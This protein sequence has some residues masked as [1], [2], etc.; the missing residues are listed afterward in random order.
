[1]WLIMPLLDDYSELPRK[2]LK[3]HCSNCG[4]EIVTIYL[5]PGD[6]LV[7]K[8]CNIETVVPVNSEESDGETT[9]D[10]LRQQTVKKE[11]HPTEYNHDSMEPS[12]WGISS[13]VKLICVYIIGFVALAIIG[14]C[15]FTIAI[16]AI[17]PET[18][19]NEELF[20]T[21]YLSKYFHALGIFD[22]VFMIFL[23]YYSVVKRH[24]NNF[25]E[26]LHLHRISK[27]QLLRYLYL[28]AATVGVVWLI[29]G[30]VGLTPLKNYIPKELPIDYYFQQGIGEIAWFSLMAVIAPIPE[31]LLFRGYMFAGFQHKL[32]TK[33]AAILVTILFVLLHGPQLAFSPYHLLMISIAAIIFVIIRIRTNSLTKCI[34]YHFFYNLILTAL[35]WGWIVIFGLES[36]TS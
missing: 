36:L 8:S 25:L 20:E 15:I 18:N 16:H 1:M 12:Q 35:L 22:S 33:W 26:A 19:A 24:H 32:G 17:I 34:V 30:V 21:V 7:C 11:I 14:G 23:I 31:E 10:R 9:A 28:A 27:P 29:E 6:V 3:F 4:A 2:K 13:V 5:Q